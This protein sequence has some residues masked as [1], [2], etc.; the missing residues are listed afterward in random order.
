MD[1]IWTSCGWVMDWLWTR[2]GKDGDKDKDKMRQ[3]QKN[4]MKR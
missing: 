1:K 2:I 4:R 3:G